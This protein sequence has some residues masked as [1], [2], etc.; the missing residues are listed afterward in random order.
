MPQSEKY[1]GKR[2][3]DLKALEQNE[4][5]LSIAI[6]TGRKIYILDNYF[7]GQHH[8]IEIS[9]MVEDLREEGVLILDFVSETRSPFSPDR[10]YITHRRKG[11]YITKEVGSE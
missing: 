10:L 9:D 6:G 7:F 2:F 3:G 8:H 11:G 5:L 4:F 1:Q